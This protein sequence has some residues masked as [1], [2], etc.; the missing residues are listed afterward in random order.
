[1]VLAK[2]VFLKI[3]ELLKVTLGK[4]V[5]SLVGSIDRRTPAGRSSAS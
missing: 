5:K 4:E 2:S 1:M 3:L